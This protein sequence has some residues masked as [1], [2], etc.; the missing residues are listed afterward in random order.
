MLNKIISYPISSDKTIKYTSYFFLHFLI[1]FF[2]SYV[3]ILIKYLLLKYHKTCFSCRFSW[4]QRRNQT[5]YILHTY[6]LTLFY[7]QKEKVIIWNTLTRV[8]TSYMDT[9][10]HRCST[11]FVIHINLYFL[12]IYNFK[13][14]D[15]RRPQWF[16]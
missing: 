6:K 14:L 16:R 5:Y 3:D 4:T 11:N 15:S 9:S 8:C 13:A 1:F 7:K 12:V 2:K 10:D